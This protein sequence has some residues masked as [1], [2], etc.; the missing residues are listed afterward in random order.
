VE[1]FLKDSWKYYQQLLE[2]RQQPRPDEADR[3]EQEF[4]VLFSTQT[5]YGALDERIVKTQAKKECLLMVLRHPEIPLHNNHAEL[6]ARAR[7][8]KRDVSFG[9]RTEEWARAWDTF[10]TL[11]AT[12]TKSGVSF[13]HYIQDCVFGAYQM[14]SLA[15]LVEEHAQEVPWAIP[16][17]LPKG[18]RDEARHQF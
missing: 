10:G 8:R 6:G 12:A 11:A 16:G 9:P 15:S 7:V 18:R 13:Y 1:A 17:C 14:P 5:G 4:D 3:L 2:Y